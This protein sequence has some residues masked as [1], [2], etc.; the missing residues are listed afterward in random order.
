MFRAWFVLLCENFGLILDS[1]DLWTEE[2]SQITKNDNI[3]NS[4]IVMF[5]VQSFQ[6]IKH[7]VKV[8]RSEFF[9]VLFPHMA[10]LFALMNIIYL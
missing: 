1:L 6:I 7:Q 4:K 2:F 8:E 9:D 10:H 5:G 3:F